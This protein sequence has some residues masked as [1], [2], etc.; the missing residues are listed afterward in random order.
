MRCAAQRS[1]ADATR[2]R[3]DGSRRLRR[4]RQPDEAPHHAGELPRERACAVLNPVFSADGPD[5]WGCACVAA[6]GEIRE[7][8]MLDLVAEVSR[9]DVKPAGPLDVG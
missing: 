7:E 8:V 2:E 3:G 6:G 5:F 4:K 9:E 1:P